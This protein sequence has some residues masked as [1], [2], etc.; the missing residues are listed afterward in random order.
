MAVAH[1]TGRFSGEQGQSLVLGIV[2]FG[3]TNFFEPLLDGFE[4]YG[5]KVKTLATRE[6]G[7]GNLFRIGRTEDKFD[8]FGRLFKCLQQRIEGLIGEHMNFVDD[9]DLEPCPARS[10][11]HIGS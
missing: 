9:I 1:R 3:A 8:M 7:D 6:D 5:N 11:V 10:Y 2:P 4:F